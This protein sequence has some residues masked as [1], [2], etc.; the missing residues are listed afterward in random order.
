M[1]ISSFQKPS[2]RKDHCC[3]NEH[4]QEHE[5]HVNFGLT[6]PRVGVIKEVEGQLQVRGRWLSV[7]G[8]DF[9]LVLYYWSIA[10]LSAQSKMITR[11]QRGDPTHQFSIS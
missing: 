9:F 8:F 1:S 10:W 5:R 6:C 11:C 7:W 3:S 4:P 2:G